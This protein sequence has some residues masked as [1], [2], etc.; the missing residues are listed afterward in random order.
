MSEHV[1]VRT[2]AEVNAVLALAAEGHAS[3]AIARVTGIPRST[4]RDWRAGRVP[5]RDGRAGVQRPCPVCAPGSVELPPREYVYLLGLYLGDGYISRGP[6]T[7]CLRFFLDGAYP[8]I[9]RA[10][11]EALEAIRPTQPAW[12][13]GAS[14]SRCHIVAMCSNHWPC[15]FP[16]HGPGRKHERKISLADWQAQLVAE[17]HEEFVRGLIH[18]DGC[19]VVANDRGVRSVRYH[20]SNKSE[21]IKRL[22]CQSLDAL[23][24]RWT[25]PCDKQIAVYRKASVAILDQFIGPK[26]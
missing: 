21:D 22:Y 16:Q 26:R 9:I 25:R 3:A 19:R 23:G 17:H 1:F 24:V 5:K 14:S 4:V 7:Y 6:R 11:R 12:D 8:G 10:C 13:K 18:S 2:Q 15:L 20:F